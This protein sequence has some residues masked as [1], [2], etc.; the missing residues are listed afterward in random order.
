MNS[1]L[2]LDMEGLSMDQV[3]HFTPSFAS[4]WLKWTHDCLP[5]RLKRVYV[6]NNSKFFTILWT[7]FGPFLTGEIKESVCILV[8]N[9]SIIVNDYFHQMRF[10]N[11][12]YDLLADYMGKECLGKEYDGGLPVEHVDGKVLLEYLKIYEEQF[13]C[14]LCKYFK[15]LKIIHPSIFSV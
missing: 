8:K 14:N 11:Q 3:I 2:I 5:L 6:V 7:L 12:Q 9:L 10:V 1:S 13:E 15:Y 4:M